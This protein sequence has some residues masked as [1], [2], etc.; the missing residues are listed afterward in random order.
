M[1][2]DEVRLRSIGARV[3]APTVSI[4]TSWQRTPLRRRLAAAVCG[5]IALLAVATGTSRAA[6]A[7]TPSALEAAFLFNFVKFTDWSGVPP[8]A[9]I[10][11]CVVNA[12]QVGAALTNSVR[13]Q[14]ID[15]HGLEVRL[16]KTEDPVSPCQ[17]LFV[18]GSDARSVL[19]KIPGGRESPLLTVS[20]AAGF[21]K[22]GGIIELFQEGGRMR[23]AINVDT[24]QQ[25][26]VRLSSRLLDLAKIVRTGNGQ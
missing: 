24:A 7:V 5:A 18:P 13:G 25:S 23:F 11:L 26:G 1:D 19:A 8:A 21:A 20:D 3:S 2:G 6:D 16:I 10:V 14:T 22:S 15:G 12:D 4:V 9:A 17:L